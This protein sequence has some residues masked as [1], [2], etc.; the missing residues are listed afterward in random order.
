[1]ESG[2]QQQS[3]PPISCT[4]CGRKFRYRP[5]LGGR[6]V[7]C[8][9][10][11]AILIPKPEKLFAD[12]DAPDDEYDVAPDPKELTPKNL[13]LAAAS[14]AL[15]ADVPAPVPGVADV[16]ALR[17]KLPPQRKGLTK[18]ERKTNEELAPPSAIRDFVLPS[19]LIAVGIALRFYEAMSPAA[20]KTPVPLGPAIGVVATNLLLSV[21][22]MLGGMF[23]AISIMEICFV[24]PLPRVAFK[25]I[26]IGIAP[27]ALYGICSFA[28]GE[29][30]G[31]MI[32]TFLSIAVYGLLFWFLMR[33]DLKDTSMCVI[34]T[35]ILVTAANYI[36]Y[37]AEG[38]MKDS[39]V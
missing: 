30:Y 4:S 6:T 33:L 2:V 7:K 21:G 38:M 12:G 35:W 1:M 8:P 39:W 34:M 31:A 23:L 15:A 9:C 28:G 26:S 11:S 37:K 29:M 3:H 32:G 14:I 5:E 10:G 19:I 24:G 16:D 25:L 17:A 22:L 27:G 13:G 18:E 20:T 36:A